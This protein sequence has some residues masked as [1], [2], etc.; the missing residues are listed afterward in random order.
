MCNKEIIGFISTQLAFKKAQKEHETICNSNFSL[1]F[2]FPKVILV[3]N[4]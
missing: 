2:H 4:S 3:R 1:A